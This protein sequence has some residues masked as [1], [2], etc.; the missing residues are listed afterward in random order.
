MDGSRN[1][2]GRSASQAATG[3]PAG[4]SQRGGEAVDVHVAGEHVE[5]RRLDA[6]GGPQPID[7]V[8]E[9]PAHLERELR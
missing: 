1:G 7:E 9:L 2:S 4:A 5:R 6:V 8:D 3:G